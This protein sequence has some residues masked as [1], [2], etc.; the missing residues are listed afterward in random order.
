MIIVYIANSYAKSK[1]DKTT[2]NICFF[3]NIIEM[4]VIIT[5]QFIP[6]SFYKIFN[7]PVFRPLLSFVL[8]VQ[9]VY[10][11]ETIVQ[12]ITIQVAITIIIEKSSVGSV[13]FFIQAIFL[14]FFSKCQVMVIDKKPIS[15]LLFPFIYA[16]I[17][18]V[19]IQPTIIVDINHHHTCIPFSFF[20]DRSY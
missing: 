10:R 3:A 12:D 13:A 11:D 18:D 20:F 6:S 7:R 2:V 8:I 1:T 15:V 5:Q 17:A 9:C 16:S 4:P 14:C 19:D